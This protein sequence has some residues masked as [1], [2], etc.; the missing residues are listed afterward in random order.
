MGFLKNYLAPGKKAAAEQQQQDIALTQKATP[1]GPS[2][3]STGKSTPWTSRPASISNDE[4][5]EG[6]WDVLA[7]WLYQEQHRRFWNGGSQD[8]GVVIKRGPRDY[9]CCPPQLADI[10][11]GFARAVQE[12]N[13]KCA[14]TVSTPLISM[15]L[16]KNTSNFVR[17]DNG[18]RLQVIPDI[19]YLP[20]CQKHHFAAFIADRGSLVVWDDLPNNLLSRV[21]MLDQALM[22]RVWNAVGD[23]EQ[24]SEKDKAQPNASVYELGSDGGDLEMAIQEAPRPLN[25]NQAVLTSLTMV[26]LMVT[27]IGSWRSIATEIGYDKS[28]IRCA[29]AVVIPLQMW[30]SLFFFQ[31][32]IGSLAQLLGPVSQ[33]HE[34]SKYYSGKKSPRIHGNGQG[35]L[36]HVTIQCPVYKEGLGTV[37]APTI[38][39]IKAA[40]S[41]YEMQGGTANIFINDDGMQLLDEEAARDRQDFY[42]ENNIGWV[43]RPAHDPKGEK[44]EAFTRAG[45][46][47]KASNMNYAMWV[48]SRIE[49]KLATINRPASWSQHEEASAYQEALLEVVQDDQG[50]TW[51]DGNIRFGD[52]ILIIDSDTRVPEDCLLD[53]VSE[54]EHSPQVGILQYS[55]GV[56]NVTNSFFERGI[57]FFTYLV[58]SAIKF[59]VANGDVAPFVGHNAILRWSAIQSIVYDCPIDQREKWWSEA[60]VSE[61]FDMALRLQADGYIVRLG[62]YTGDGFQEGVSLTVYDEL[63]RWEKYAYGCGEL[64]F[65]PMKS[66]IFKGPFTPL[67]RRFIA[68]KMPLASKITIMAYIGTYYA[69]GAA[70]ILTLANY[71]LTGLYKP[72]LDKYSLDSFQIFLSIIVV[73]S[74]LGNIGLAAMRYRLGEKS[75]IGSLIENFSWI[76]LLFIFLGGVSIHISQ[77]LV[78]YFLSFDMSWGATAKEVDDASFFDEIPKILK[79]FKVT[80]VYCILAAVMMGVGATV[81]PPLWRITQF[82]A[83]FPL[84]VNIFCHF[85]LPLLLNPSLM[86]FTF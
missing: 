47:K 62:G 44:G 85:A 48:S 65:H 86:R 28:Y 63:A 33:V 66:W 69:L 6:K 37:I 60:T 67:F 74:A 68:S 30:V 54:M 7:L 57:T 14:I 64:V 24:E 53:A 4:I 21:E 3:Y 70:W 35:S 20:N 9:T 61:D 76:P 81:L 5:D 41:T 55:S 26:L 29:L 34:N 42:D 79:K 59:A 15:F 84:A 17:L 32:L 23:K 25:L 43:A 71:F 72:A 45:K 13:V 78:S 31:S 22:T 16:S 50:R 49:D 18:L 12:L 19:S 38:R 10:P 52:Y 1:L 39:S 80:L 51:A 46:F 11:D 8:E 83:I 40:I 58:Y 56:M 82:V 75:L 2:G 27:I 73:F 36:P 77:A